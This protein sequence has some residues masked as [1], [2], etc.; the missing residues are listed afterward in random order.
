MIKA[1]SNAFEVYEQQ[2]NW[3]ARYSGEDGVL[4]KANARY[5]AGVNNLGV[6]LSDPNAQDDFASKELHLPKDESLK[7]LKI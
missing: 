2:F 1:S 7:I 3:E 4:G 6:D 5:V